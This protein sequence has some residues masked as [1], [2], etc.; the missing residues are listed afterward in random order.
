MNEESLKPHKRDLPREEESL[1][2]L[3]R[4]CPIDEA[5]WAYI[6]DRLTDPPR[7]FSF[8]D[9]HDDEGGDSEKHAELESDRGASEY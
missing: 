3:L 9:W 8:D 4:R 2:D 6:L 1:L 7:E 5:T